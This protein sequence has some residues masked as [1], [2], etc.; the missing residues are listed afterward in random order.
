M[1]PIVRDTIQLVC[2]TQQAVAS[3]NRTSYSLH[4]CGTSMVLTALANGDGSHIGK[5]TRNL[6][7]TALARAMERRSAA[8]EASL[9][10]L[11]Q[12]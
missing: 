11:C 2:W 8:P 4:K 6:C 12:S 7:P 5:Q 9:N 3:S 1:S 10:E